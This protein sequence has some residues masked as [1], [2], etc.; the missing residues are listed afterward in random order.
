MFSWRIP[1]KGLTHCPS[2]DDDDLDDDSIPGFSHPAISSTPQSAVFDKGKGRATDQ[3]ATPIGGAPSPRTPTLSGN[4]GST[5]TGAP[6]PVRRVVG[7]VQVESRY[8]TW[9]DSLLSELM[10]RVLKAYWDRYSR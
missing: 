3:L 2:D 9:D 8:V 10:T 1:H 7:G 4:I 5:P 6:K